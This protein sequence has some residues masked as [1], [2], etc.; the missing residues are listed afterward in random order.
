LPDT[1]VRRCLQVRLVTD[2]FSGQPRGFGFAH[3]DSA[4]DAAKVLHTF[5]VRPLMC[6]V[7]PCW[8]LPVRSLF[9]VAQLAAFQRPDTE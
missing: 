1:A 4:A 5:N 8:Q 3:F 6:T 9:R 7:Q 2:R